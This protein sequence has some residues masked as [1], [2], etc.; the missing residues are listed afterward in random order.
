MLTYLKNLFIGVD[1]ND[2]IPEAFE[3]DPVA[4]AFAHLSE[5]LSYA[6][7]KAFG[8]ECLG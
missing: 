6:A 5:Y 2:A 7:W 8:M 1:D 4:P 3:R